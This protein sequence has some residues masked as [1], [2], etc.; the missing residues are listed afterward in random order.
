MKYS[1][2]NEY[3]ELLSEE[4]VNIE[5]FNPSRNEVWNIEIENVEA[6]VISNATK[7][8]TSDPTYSESM[9]DDGSDL[10]KL[11]EI[12]LKYSLISKAEIVK[13]FSEARKKNENFKFRIK[14]Q[15][16][17]QII[18]YLNDNFKEFCLG[19]NKTKNAIGIGELCFHLAFETTN[20]NTTD[21]PDVVLKLSNGNE[22]RISIA[23]EIKT[24]EDWHEDVYD[25]AKRHWIKI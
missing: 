19:S 17:E 9:S 23:F 2:K 12:S 5:R 20:W 14:P 22:E 3:K 13:F 11:H 8:D 10:N 24:K 25:G 18:A 1:L 16:K 21:E 4:I 15:S 6:G 7:V